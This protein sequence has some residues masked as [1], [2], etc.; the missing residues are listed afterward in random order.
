MRVT[1]AFAAL[2]VSGIAS[3]APPTKPVPGTIGLRQR[4]VA[5]R[6][7]CVTSTTVITQVRP[8][9]A[10]ALVAAMQLRPIRGLSLDQRRAA[11]SIRRFETWF[12]RS[13]AVVEAAITAAHAEAASAS[14]PV[15]RVVALASI[16]QVNQRLAEVLRSAE[17]PADV[18]SYAEA[19]AVY[20][21]ALEEKAATIDA[22]ANAARRVCADAAAHIL[23]G[24]W[25]PICTP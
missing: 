7:A 25:T 20:C 19:T 8:G 6:N 24:W 5:L 3:A 18:R 4:T 1:L 16:V 21:D 13:L 11:A 9:D 23:P 2:L 17:I 12:A 15:D 10:P 22:Q 14:R